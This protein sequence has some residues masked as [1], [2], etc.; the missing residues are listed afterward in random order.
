MRLE[1]SVSSFA[2]PQVKPNLAARSK[3]RAMSMPAI[4]LAAGASRRL[5]QPKQLV[6]VEGETMLARTVR[7]VLECAARPVLVVLGA[8]HEMIAAGVDLS[9]AHVVINAL[10]EEGIASSIRAGLAELLRV[11]PEAEAA[12]LLVCDQPRLSADHLSG[13]RA[14]YGSAGAAAIAAS[15][16]E[17]IAGIPA[18]FPVSQFANLMALQGDVGARS[19]LRN[20]QCPMV[21]RHF[22]GGEVDIDTPSDLQ[23][24]RDFVE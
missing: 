7:V 6:R 15:E 20:P 19:L 17:G 9:D 24:V 5:G 10:W 12:L 4:I 18:I 22:E 13:L 11:A 1:A 21:T 8:S 23:G 14:A 3:L 2:K 16:Y